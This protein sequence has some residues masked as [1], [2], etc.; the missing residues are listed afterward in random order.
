MSIKDRAHSARGATTAP[1]LFQRSWVN[2]NRHHKPWHSRACATDCSNH[3][4]PPGG[5]RGLG[6]STAINHK[7]QQT[8]ITCPYTQYNIGVLTLRT[9]CKPSGSSGTVLVLSW[10]T[11][12][13]PPA[14]LHL[15]AAS[16]VGLARLP[17]ARPWGDVV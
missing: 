8:I 1:L 2:T 11:F 9:A 4:L 3:P 7:S 10:V 16:R 13:M 17:P 6:L 12:I 5:A 15:W 14:A